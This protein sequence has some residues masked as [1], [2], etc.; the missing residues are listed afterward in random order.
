MAASRSSMM[1]CRCCSVRISSCRSRSASAEPALDLGRDLVLPDGLRGSASRSSARL[2]NTTRKY[3]PS[4][5][6]AVMRRTSN[7]T[8]PISPS[9]LSCKMADWAGPSSLFAFERSFRNSPRIHSRAILGS[10][11]VACPGARRKY[12]LVSPCDWRISKLSF[13]I[14]HA[15]A[16][17]DRTMRSATLSSSASND[18]CLPIDGAGGGDLVAAR[19]RIH[20]R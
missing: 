17:S 1:D 15:G 13:T 11:S 9:P 14:A 3:R 19:R 8:V 2:K 16:C 4:L 12:G 10:A 20:G 6:G 5:V 7:R 18:F